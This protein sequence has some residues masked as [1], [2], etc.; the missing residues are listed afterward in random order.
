M[1][2]FTTFT[3]LG[4]AD[5]S[6]DDLNMYRVVKKVSHHAT[7]GRSLNFFFSGILSITFNKAITK[8]DPNTPGSKHDLVLVSCEIRN[9]Q[10]LTDSV[11]KRLRY[12]GVF[13]HDFYC[14]FTVH[15]ARKRILKIGQHLV[16]L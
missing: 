2:L 8:E 14:K 6:N 11:A 13:S 16:Q 3:L 7:T 1:S 15:C 5:I 12:A 4:F 9:F 10:T